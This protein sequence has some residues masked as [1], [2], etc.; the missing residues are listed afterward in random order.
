MRPL[1]KKET[2]WAVGISPRTVDVL[3]GNTHVMYGRQVLCD[4]FRVQVDAMEIDEYVR[5]LQMGNDYEA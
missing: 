3:N 4:A 2:E 1:G 5:R